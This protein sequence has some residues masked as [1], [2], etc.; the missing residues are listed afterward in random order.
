MNVFSKVTTETL[1]KNRVRTLVTIAGIIL[2]VA[3]FTAVTTTVASLQNYMVEVTKSNDGSWHAALLNTN[4]NQVQKVQQDER[5]ESTVVLRQLGYSTSCMEDC[6]N[7]SK[8]Y[9]YVAAMEG[10][11]TELLPVKLIEGRMPENS[12][13]IIIPKHLSTNG[14]VNLEMGQTLN[15]SIGYRNLAGVQ[16]FQKEGFYRVLP[17]LDESIT[18]ELEN[19]NDP[20]EVQKKREELAEVEELVLTG[21][22]SYTVVGF[23][24][25]PSFEPY[26][27]PGYT[28]LTLAEEEVMEEDAGYYDVYFSLK[29]MNLYQTFLN[30]Y[31]DIGP[32]D[33]ENLIYQDMA[34]N[35][36]F[37]RYSGAAME[38]SFN[39]VLYSMAAIFIGIIMFGSISLIY[40]AFSISL[41]ERTKQFGLMKSIGATKKQILGSVLFEGIVLSGIA[42]PIGV[43]SGIAGIG[44]TLNLLSEPLKAM[45]GMSSEIS[46]RMCVSVPAIIIAVLVG[47]LTVLIS[48]YLPAKR[49]VRKNPIDA[50][51]QSGDIAIRAEKVRGGRVIGRLFGLPGMLASKNFRRNKKKYRATVVSL[52]ASIVLFIS[53]SSFCDYLSL[54]V[55][56]IVSDD[57]IDLVF[58]MRENEFIDSNQSVLE[59][60]ENFRRTEGVEKIL[61][62]WSNWYQTKPI[63]AK[64]SKEYEEYCNSILK[65]QKEMGYPEN[66]PDLTSRV[67]VHFIDDTMYREFLTEQGLDV[68]YF[69]NA[70]KPIGLM[71]D[72]I[73]LHHQ[74]ES[75]YYVFP[76]F[77]QE[78]MDIDIIKSDSDEISDS[79]TRSLHI[80][81]RFH[82]GM[83]GMSD[84]NALLMVTYPYSARENVLGELTLAENR[85][86]SFSASS[87]KPSETM[88]KLKNVCT[89]K[90]FGA[91]GMSNLAANRESDR[92][93]ILVIKVFSYGFITLIS[94]IA[95]ANVF[96]TISTNINLRR[97]E[98]AMLRS[99]GLTKRGM[100]QM[101]NYECLLYG[102]KSLLFGLPASFLVTWLI[103]IGLNFGMDMAFYIPWISVLIAVGSVFAVVFAT[104]LYSMSKVKKDNPIDALRNEN[105]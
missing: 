17:R 93:V 96:N 39:Q 8:P 35:S 16:R 36:D 82:G 84:N 86:L 31:M 40:N 28:A 68:E 24:E 79:E 42:I 104:M 83:F 97:R 70:Q 27:A 101:M 19:P 46:I 10:F 95:A 60:C 87:K 65:G 85:T 94:L 103:Y 13:E 49:A 26:S 52:F 23:Y 78:T 54:G 90:G 45:Q 89:E 105:M 53:T 74:F 81:G 48:A 73:K 55:N 12:S 34:A 98:F 32:S 30:E 57:G 66:P 62:D 76:V 9:L 51:R 50:I 77:A 102:L 7:S 41:S 91:V 33:G 67:M 4:E 2:S 92:A 63:T 61:F 21:Q 72:N 58:Y 29:K 59:L 100:R 44:V 69:M 22:R 64:Y 71:N 14:G 88:E 5:V 80:G 20:D 11:V 38:T 18:K 43:I 15:L 6:V 75:R 37:L 56:S 47:V 3:M 99:I 1:K 25:R